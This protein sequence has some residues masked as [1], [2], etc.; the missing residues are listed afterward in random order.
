[1]DEW[2]PLTA[3]SVAELTALA[4]LPRAV[5]AGSTDVAKVGN[6]ITYDWTLLAGRRRL[7]PA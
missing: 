5:C 3:G 7:T 6:Q 1:V 2:K 4:V